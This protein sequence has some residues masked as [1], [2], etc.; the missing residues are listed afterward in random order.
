MQKK[1]VN[2]VMISQKLRSLIY[3]INNSMDKYGM[4]Q[5]VDLTRGTR[6]YV[7]PSRR[8]GVGF[9]IKVDMNDVEMYADECGISD[10]E[11]AK[12]LVTHEIMH[13]LL[14][15]FNKNYRQWNHEIFNLAADCEVNS[16]LN[17]GGSSIRAQQFGLPDFLKV[18]D[19][20]RFI[21]GQSDDQKKQEQK[22]SIQI[23]MPAEGGSS[24]MMTSSSSSGESQTASTS[25]SA[26]QDN[27]D[28]SENS[29]KSSKSDDKTE[30][31]NNADTVS[32]GEKKEEEK[33]Q[34]TDTDLKPKSDSNPNDLQPGE[35]END[36]DGNANAKASGNTSDDDEDDTDEPE[37]EASE[38]M[39][40]ALEKSNGDSLTDKYSD[41]E[42]EKIDQI[43]KQ[44]G[45]GDENIQ[46]AATVAS[47][48]I[49]RTMN[50]NNIEGLDELMRKLERKEMTM[51]ITPHTR[52]E[53]YMKLN[54]RRRNGT[55]IL[56]GK[57]LE[58]NGVKKKFDTSLTVFIDLSG[59]TWDIN[60]TLMNVAYRFYKLGATIV[61]YDTKILDIVKPSERFRLMESS[62]GTNIKDVLAEY[63]E[64][65]P[66][67]DRAYVIT[68][69]QDNFYAMDEV[70]PKYNIYLIERRSI[71]EIY[72]DKN[73]CANKRYW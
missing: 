18:T 66:K 2:E 30:E 33:P 26:S 59:S 68:D 7:T 36:D 53:T 67:L 44:Y 17:T 39:K 34:P 35:D 21:K 60:E 10:L 1:N 22:I 20:Y 3:S 50:T 38:Q 8:Y 42:A 4:F 16:Y 73:P 12:I 19:Y 70:V 31:V 5:N 23:N 72:N 29:S 24:D 57:R 46:R 64:T 56:P 47:K 25:S 52:K 69:G 71:R 40:K 51:G 62:G 6:T 54:N 58:N 28:Q 48:A 27:Q 37:D 41:E 49:E 43:A 63:L 13:V 32:E 15:H 65:N 9:D 61:Y 14:D 45:I 11:A 55:I